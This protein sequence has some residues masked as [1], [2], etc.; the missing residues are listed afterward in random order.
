MKSLSKLRSG[1]AVSV[2]YGDVTRPETIA[3]TVADNE[4]EYGADGNPAGGAIVLNDE[5]GQEVFLSYGI[6]H[7]WKQLVRSGSSR[8]ADAPARRRNAARAPN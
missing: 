2:T 1:D 6:I 5:S 4:T 7:G 8:R 3:G